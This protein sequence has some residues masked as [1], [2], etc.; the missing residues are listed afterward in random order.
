MMNHVKMI[1]VGRHMS[2]WVYG[3]IIILSR[4]RG[5]RHRGGGWP[6]YTRVKKE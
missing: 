1:D 5:A 3:T 4:R 2:R 6:R